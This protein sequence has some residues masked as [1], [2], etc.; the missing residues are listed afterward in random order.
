MTPLMKGRPKLIAILASSKYPL[1][2][3]EMFF[4][5]I[6]SVNE[7]DGGYCG[8]IS[9]GACGCEE[10]DELDSEGDRDVL[11]GQIRGI[12]VAD[13]VGTVCVCSIFVFIVSG[14][15]LAAVV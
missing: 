13:A 4:A 5:K 2:C 14:A 15:P 12:P 10:L 3:H 7:P 11:R 1:L 6:A 8:I 9:L